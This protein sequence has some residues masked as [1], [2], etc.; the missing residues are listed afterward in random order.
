MTR[1]A[2]V[3]T[4]VAAGP[5]VADSPAPAPAPPASA[6]PAATPAEIQIDVTDNGTPTFTGAIALSFGDCGSVEAGNAAAHYDIHVCFENRT[7][8]PDLVAIDL[9]RT[10]HGHAELHQKLKTTSRIALGKRVVL[11][12]FGAGADTTEVAATV[13]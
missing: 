9:D 6:A 5:A 1:F 12:R 3:F 13:K 10:V 11:G 8:S 7:G 4:L 2:L